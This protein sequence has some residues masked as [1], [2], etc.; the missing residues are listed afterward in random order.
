MRE[1]LHPMVKWPNRRRDPDGDSGADPKPADATQGP[2]VSATDTGDATARDGATAV[3]GYTGPPAPGAAGAVHV[4]DTGAATA[5]E[6][7]LANTGYLAIDRF[8]LVQQAA[9][10][11]PAAWP[12][13][14]GVIPTRALSFQHRTEVDQ[15]RTAV[16]GGGTAVLSQ[17]LTGTGGVGKTQ[18]AADYARTAWDSGSVDVLVWISA[19]SRSA[20]ANGYAQAG[21]EVLGADPTDPEKAT[22]EFLAWLEPKTGTKPCR[23]LVVLDDLV[24]PAD[25]RGLWPPTSSRGRTLVTTRRRDAALTGA[26]RRL[27]HVGLFMPWEAAAYLT[28]VLAAHGRTEPAEQIN[29]LGTDLGHLPLALAQAAAYLVDTE[30]AC[31]DYRELFADRMRKLADLLP[32]SSSL[33]DDQAITVAATWSL[34]IERA[35]QLRPAGL[36]RPMIQLAA[37]LDPNGIP[38]TVLTAKPVL[39][40]LTEHRTPATT[41][42]AHPPAQ[43]SAEDAVLALRALHRLNLID[44]SPTTPHQAV[45]VHRLIQRATRDS[46]IPDQRDRLTRTAADALTAVWP[47]IERDTTLARALR[48]NTTALIAGAE[49]ALYRPTPHGVLIRTGQSLGNTGL[50]NPA[51]AYFRHLVEATD[52]R[53]GS[54]HPFV[55]AVRYSFVQWQ[56]ATADVVVAVAMCEELL[57]DMVRVLGPDHPDTL[58]TRAL[59]AHCKGR[60][61]DRT[62]AVS[63]LE[64]LLADRVRV[65]GPDHPDTLHTRNNLSHWQGAD[66]GAA[67][68]AVAYEEL[69]A[70]EARVLGPDH[71][72]TLH[73]RHGLAHGRSEA[74]DPAGA[75]AAFE[76]LLADEVR[77]LGPDHPD[78]LTTRNNLA[79]ARGEA[80]DVAGAVAAYEELLPDMVRVLGAHHPHTKTTRGNLAHWQHEAR[81]PS[82]AA[83]RAALQ[84]LLNPA[85]AAASDAID[86]LLAD[87]ERQRGPHPPNTTNARDRSSRQRA[88][89][90]DSQGAVSARE[91]LPSDH[92][93]A[94]TARGELAEARGKAGDV[95][96]A[97]A[98]YE[99]LLADM[100]RV[101]GPDHPHTLFTRVHLARWR[102]EAG[103]PA[104]AVARLEELRVDAVQA[105]GRHHRV[106][107]LADESLFLWRAKARSA[108]AATVLEELPSDHPKALAARK[109]IAEVQGISGDAAGAA[110]ALGQLLVDVARVLGPDHPDTLTIRRELAGWRR[111]TGDKAG[112][113]AALEELMVDV[114]RVLGPDHPDTLT[115][116]EELARA[117]GKAGDPAGAVAAYEEL[118]AAQVRVLGPYAPDTLDTH[119]SLAFWRRLA[120]V[121]ESTD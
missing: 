8:T 84:L 102:G 96:G 95:A 45:R 32:E 51:T 60:A 7:G 14:V 28:E 22:R 106:I 17:V 99:E 61:G 11:T 116:Q 18:L 120:I 50:V 12:H 63:V 72:H 85:D 110:A 69:L 104:G 57:V 67:G 41:G 16:D 74:G 76:E 65:L 34:S 92:P 29:G 19:S 24:D 2:A 15:L 5:G 91:E 54:D 108:A 48:A 58:H 89:A 35:D 53:L 78:T 109:E 70:D 31:A 75:V 86:E 66:R 20:I 3:S 1:D 49:D 111:W 73:A 80:G 105:L 107:N 33:P 64:E 52:H 36:A 82:G 81:N 59:L 98:A 88:E 117:R 115:T 21:V 39:T 46:L 40:L 10:R 121:D 38:A 25:L 9:P 6:G 93:D 112:V 26:G 87:R 100:M 90:G 47:D 113:A 79:S 13:Q 27:V 77:V 4:S 97:V 43:V 83:F 118:L 114:V 119:E 62:S 30:L 37:L 71:P 44:H 42:T 55:L 94:L 101:L 103:D 56:S 23:W 68:A